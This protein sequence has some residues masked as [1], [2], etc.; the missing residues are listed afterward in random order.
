[1]LGIVG[2]GNPGSE[3]AR[4]RHNIG[5]MVVSAFADKHHI[6]C[7]RE[8]FKSEYG[9]GRVGQ[10]EAMLIMPQTFMNLS[11]QSVQG[12]W[13]FYHWTGDDLVVVHDEIDLPLGQIKFAF[14]RGAA[15]HNGIKS[16]IESIGTQGFYRLRVG[17]GRPKGQQP[18][19]D[20][21]LSSFA[22]S[23][24]NEVQQE[25]DRACE[26]LHCFVTEGA[27]KAMQLF[28]SE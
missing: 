15:G 3:F 14:G 9:K 7:D 17:V 13:N 16:I 4:T 19:A 1:M 27:A 2:L 11:G 8:K 12:W 26:A 25:I 20:Y 5:F 10:Q 24:K 21:V 22:G 28:H 18:V 23:E 6:A